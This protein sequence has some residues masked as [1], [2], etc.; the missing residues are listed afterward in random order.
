[1]NQRIAVRK[2]GKMIVTETNIKEYP[3]LTR[4]KVRDVYDLGQELLIIAT[5]RKWE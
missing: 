1:M 5:D 3:L 2:R 4:G